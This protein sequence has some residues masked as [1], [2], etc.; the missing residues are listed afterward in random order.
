LKLDI[1]PSGSGYPALLGGGKSNVNGRLV[2]VLSRASM[3]ISWGVGL[4]LVIVTGMVTGTPA[5]SLV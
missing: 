5:G 4:L 1:D 3:K 2:V